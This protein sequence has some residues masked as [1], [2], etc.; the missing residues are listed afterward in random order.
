M[1]YTSVP[2]IGP[3]QIADPLRQRPQELPRQISRHVKNATPIDNCTAFTGGGS[4]AM[5]ASFHLGLKQQHRCL[6]LKQ[7]LELGRPRH[8]AATVDKQG[9]YLRGYKSSQ[10][11]LLAQ[12]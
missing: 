6:K 8:G 10:T 5:E 12:L 1:H 4:D 3:P 2:I 7:R 11:K 9:R